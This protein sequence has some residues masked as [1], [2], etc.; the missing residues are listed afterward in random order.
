MEIQN[1]TMSAKPEDELSVSMW[2]K[3]IQL[4]YYICVLC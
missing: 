4:Y 1:S 2:F 3:R